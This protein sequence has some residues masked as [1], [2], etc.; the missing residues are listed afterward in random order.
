MQ[1]GKLRVEKGPP[2]VGV[3]DASVVQHLCHEVRGRLAAG[4][5][6]GDLLA[7]LHPTPAVAGQPPRRARE[8]IAGMEPFDRGLYAGPVGCCSQAGTEVAVAIRSA[9]FETGRVHLYAG[10]GLL[11][12]SEA[13]A[14]WQESCDKMA[15]LSALLRD[16]AAIRSGKATT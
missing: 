15:L 11:P 6:D 14:E 13:E 9:L 7:A 2:R 3:V 5:G 16:P 4:V 10:V 1:I 8:V 12:A